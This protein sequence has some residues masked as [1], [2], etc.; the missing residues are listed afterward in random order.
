VTGFYSLQGLFNPIVYNKRKKFE[1]SEI[2]NATQTK[3]DDK[4]QTRGFAQ[5]S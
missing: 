4:V 2:T 5:H 3:A 1:F